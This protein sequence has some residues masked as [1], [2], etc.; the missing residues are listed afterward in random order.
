MRAGPERDRVVY[1]AKLKQRE[2]EAAAAA[3]AAI[4]RSEEGSKS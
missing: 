3:R 4:A 2:Q 1:E